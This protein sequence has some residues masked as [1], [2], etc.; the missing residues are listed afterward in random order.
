M[1]IRSVMGD[2]RADLHGP[3][4]LVIDGIGTFAF[5]SPVAARD[6]AVRL[7]ELV[8]NVRDGLERDGFDSGLLS[9]EG[10][11]CALRE[12]ELDLREGRPGPS[13]AP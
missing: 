1:A 11:L 10:I 5:A 12:G 9:N 4:S 7:C 8:H 6:E 3:V 13:A 2:I